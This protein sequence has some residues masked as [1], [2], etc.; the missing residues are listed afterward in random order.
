MEKSV[1]RNIETKTVPNSQKL[2]QFLKKRKLKLPEI[3]NN[4]KQMAGELK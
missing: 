1:K 3:C 2:K 4:P